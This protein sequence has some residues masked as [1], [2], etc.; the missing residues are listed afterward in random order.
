MLISRDYKVKLL[1]KAIDRAR[2]I[3]REKALERVTKEKEKGR[4]VFSIEYHP[5]L[6]S[7]SH[8][9]KKTLESHGG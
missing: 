8:I 9:F 7:I 1:D 6:P 4:P 5:A 2:T 3:P